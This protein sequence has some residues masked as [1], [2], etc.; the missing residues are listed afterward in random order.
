MARF[1]VLMA[2]AISLAAPFVHRDD[3]TGGNEAN[4]GQFAFQRAELLM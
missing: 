2:G 4:L 3:A 1:L